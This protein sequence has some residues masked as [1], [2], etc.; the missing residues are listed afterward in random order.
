MPVNSGQMRHRFILYKSE[1]NRDEFGSDESDLIRVGVYW[2]D[3]S[4]TKNETT[5]STIRQ[6]NDYLKLITRYNKTLDEVNNSNFVEFKGAIYE[7][8][9]VINPKLLNE[10]LEIVCVKKGLCG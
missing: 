9:S 4:N 1:S 7:I 8:E 6:T 2:C 5:G 3:V 10:R